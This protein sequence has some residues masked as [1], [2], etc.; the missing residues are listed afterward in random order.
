MGEE[1]RHCDICMHHGKGKKEEELDLDDFKASNGWA[2]NL[3]RCHGWKMRHRSRK[4]K[5]ANEASAE[6]AKHAISRLLNDLATRPKE[7]FDCDETTII[8]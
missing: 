2:C 6:L 4:G 8:F 1:A 3:V 7:V 5:D